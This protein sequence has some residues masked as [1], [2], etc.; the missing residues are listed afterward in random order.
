MHRIVP[1][2]FLL[3]GAVI[4]GMVYLRPQWGEF[5]VLKKRVDRLGELNRKLDLLGKERD[6]LQEKIAAIPED[7]Q[8]RLAQ[9]LPEG[10]DTRGLLILMEER[11]KRD[12]ILLQG[13]TLETRKEAKQQTPSQPRPAGG[14]SPI[15]P[16]AIKELPFQLSLRG[17]YD[18]MKRFL[19]TL[20]KSLRLIDTTSLSFQ[21]PGQ[22]NTIN[23]NINASAYH[24]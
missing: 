19:N 4:I 21:A 20:E 23:F 6:K 5:S 13:V 15:S 24:Q 11:T 1:A 17:T 10:T 22:E 16:T 9:A 14:I 3:F 2:I 7:A 12:G 8:K 18:A